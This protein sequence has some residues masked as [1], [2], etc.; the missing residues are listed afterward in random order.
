MPTEILLLIFNEILGGDGYAMV[1]HNSNWRTGEPHIFNKGHG[2][3]ERFRHL[4]G[5]LSN[6]MLSKELR[7]IVQEAFFS[8]NFFDL[9]RCNFDL[10]WLRGVAPAHLELIRKVKIEV[11]LVAGMTTALINFLQANCGIKVIAV[12]SP[13][14]KYWSDLKTF[15]ELPEVVALCRF[16]GLRIVKIEFDSGP[17][18]LPIAAEKTWLEAAMKQKR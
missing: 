2:F 8:N 13:T 5:E 16:R 7:P 1:V 12:T 9:T 15:Q 17:Y 14:R 18:S 4:G 11:S 3:W 6:Y 10:R